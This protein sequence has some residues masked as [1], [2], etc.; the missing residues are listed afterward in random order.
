MTTFR[1]LVFSKTTGDVAISALIGNRCYPDKLPQKPIYPLIVYKGTSEDESDYRTHDQG[2][3]TERTVSFVQFE[4]YSNQDNPDQ[5]AE[6][7]VLIIAA[8]GGYQAKPNVGYSFM[9][10]RFESANDSLNAYR[11]IVEFNVEHARVLS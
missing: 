3:Q 4:C 7:A 2:G 10:N 11:E 5:A 8:W 1:E 6:L 9:Q